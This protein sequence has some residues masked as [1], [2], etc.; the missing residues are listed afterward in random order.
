MQNEKKSPFIVF[1][2]IDGSGKSTQLKMLSEKLNLLGI[3]NVCQCEPTDSVIGKEIR[4][5][6]SGKEKVDPKTMAL[7]FAADRI[8]HITR[9]G[10]ILDNTQ[11]GITVLSDRY[12]FSSYAYQM[13]DMP[14]E[15]VIEINSM[16]QKLAKPDLHIFV[17]VS[18]E[19]CLERIS[20]NRDNI[21]IFENEKRLTLARENFLKIIE[22][23][24]ETEKVLV[25]DGSRPVEDV[26]NEI[27]N[28]VKELF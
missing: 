15:W 23:T 25:V 9:K 13:V 1:E 27:W 8:E 17:D 28:N 5:I 6:L 19:I 24:K 7:L 18:P 10:G 26:S 22:S 14:L 11:N 16:A 3:E 21:E 20:K 2:G 4:N 12:Y